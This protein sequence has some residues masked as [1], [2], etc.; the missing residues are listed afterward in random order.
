M[1]IYEGINFYMTISLT[2][3]YSVIAVIVLSLYWKHLDKSAKLTIIFFLVAFLLETVNNL[4]INDM[5]S[6]KSQQ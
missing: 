6:Q 2:I 1:Q 3:I 5:Q 4:L